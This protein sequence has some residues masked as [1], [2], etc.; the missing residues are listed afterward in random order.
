MNERTKTGLEVL[1]ASF[2]LGILGNILLRETP[3]GLNVFLFVAAFVT[4]AVMLVLRRKPEF[5]TR[6][7]AALLGAM[8]FFSAMFVWRDSIELRLYD[9]GAILVIMGVLML[10]AI[11]IQTKVAGVFHYAVGLIWSGINSAFAPAVLLS[12]DIKWASIPKTGWSKHLL[13]AI[14]GLLIA[15]PLLLIFGALFVAADAVYQ[16]MVERV[17]NIPAETIL[18]HLLLTAVF[19]WLSAGYFRGL[20]FE[21]GVPDTAVAAE[22]SNTGDT[23]NLSIFEQV[24]AEDTVNP[25]A[26]PDNATILDH[27]NKSDPPNS[28][29]P[30]Q[31]T[32]KKKWQ[33]QN[34]D[35]SV[36]PQVFTLVVV[37]TSIVLGLINLLFL[38]FVIV[39]VPY[40]FGGMELVQ[41]TPDFKLAEY[42]RRG[43]GELVAVTALVLPILLLSHWLL[44]KDSPINEKIYRILAG[45][46]IVLLFVIMASAVQRLFLLTGNLGYGLTTVRFYPMVVMIWFAIVFVWFS[47]TVLRG[48][49][50]HFAWGALWSALFVLGAVHVVNPD[51][52]IVRTNIRL[53]NEGR[54]FDSRYNS[55]LSDDAIPALLESVNSMS[56]ENQCVVKSKL[57]DRLIHARTENDLRNWN[58]SRSKALA[59]L[60]N[61]SGG[62]DTAGCPDHLRWTSYNDDF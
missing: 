50:Q 53:M 54:V 43:F 24:K 17:F 21:L 38:T 46:Q 15:L 30:S 14:R 62:L 48:A 9:T 35:N 47:L 27:I 59:G 40:L 12:A 26:L 2:L 61:V 29:T 31:L 28:E 51:E 19:F 42:A 18:T 16:G 32:E 1:Q 10:P 25:D 45:V 4:A 33:W 3:W 36:I 6:Q 23:Q 5:W 37:E 60:E 41:N 55:A 49:R 11:K 39:Q 22:S 58:W 20:L 7:N 8:L 57:S 56:Y 44:R 52:F 13:S 34:F